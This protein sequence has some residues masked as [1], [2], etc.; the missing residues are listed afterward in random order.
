MK[1]SIPFGHRLWKWYYFTSMESTYIH[2]ETL[3]SL[4]SSISKC[5]KTSCPLL[6]L[7]AKVVSSSAAF[8]KAIFVNITLLNDYKAFSSCIHGKHTWKKKIKCRHKCFTEIKSTPP[9]NTKKTNFEL[10]VIQELSNSELHMNKI[11]KMYSILHTFLKHI[12]LHADSSTH[13]F[14]LTPQQ[15]E[16]WAKITHPGKHYYESF[17]W[18]LFEFCRWVRIKN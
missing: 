15:K 10:I 2:S 3:S 6:T 11:T 16:N 18:I 12:S 13:P 4:L 5:T 7:H 1:R 14:T 17:V 9:V 8:D